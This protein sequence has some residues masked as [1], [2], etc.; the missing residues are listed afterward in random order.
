MP[1]SPRAG[2][3]VRGLRIDDED[4]ADLGDVAEAMDLDRGWLLRQLVRWYLGRPG[5][6][7]PPRPGDPT[8]RH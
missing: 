5:A 8:G 6:E 1:N 3:S 2:R 4:W 7:P